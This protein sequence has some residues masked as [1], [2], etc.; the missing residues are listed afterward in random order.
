LLVGSENAA[1]DG[2]RF[3]GVFVPGRSLAAPSR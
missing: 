2:A 1:S 3:P